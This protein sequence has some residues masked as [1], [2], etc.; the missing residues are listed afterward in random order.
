MRVSHRV[1]RRGTLSYTAKA[2]VVRAL[3][4]CIA[5]LGVNGAVASGAS[6]LTAPVGRGYER[7]SPLDKNG[8]DV[9]PVSAD[10]AAGVLSS[11]DGETIVWPAFGSF[12]GS[13]SALV[14]AQYLSRRAIGEWTTR[15]ISPP[16]V[17]EPLLA[18]T[19]VLAVSD[20]HSRAVVQSNAELV[21][22]APPSNLFGVPP[23]YV[24]DLATGTYELVS[25]RRFDGS[26][27]YNAN[28][29]GASADARHIL[30]E[31]DAEL[32]Q[33][34]IGVAGTRLYTWSNGVLSLSSMLPGNPGA[35]S[36]GSA[37]T[38][39]LSADELIDNAV[40][41]DGSQV[42][43]TAPAVGDESRRLYV[44]AD[45]TTM[46]V[47]EEEN[48]TQVIP[49]GPADFRGATR[50]G[51]KIFFTSRQQLVAAD[52]N[53]PGTDDGEDLYAYSPSEAPDTDANLTLLSKN[54]FPGAESE[55]IGFLGA[56][57]DGSR[58]YF[59]ANGELVDGAQ[60]NGPKL[61]MY[62]G[63]TDQVKLV[64]GLAGG[65]DSLMWG[66][67]DS[68]RNLSAVSG[69]GSALLFVT[70]AS[71]TGYNNVSSRCDG[72]ICPQVFYYDASTST[73]TGP[74]VKC[75]SCPATEGEALG[76][77]RLYASSIYPQAGLERVKDR[78]NLSSNGC[79]AFFES[80]E[81][82]APTDSNGKRDVYMWEA[83]TPYLMSTGQSDR[84][85]LFADASASGNDVFF[86]TTERLVGWDSDDLYDLYDARVGGG[87]PEPAV[88]PEPCKEDACQGLPTPRAVLP[89][90]ATTTL[91][92]AGNRRPPAREPVRGRVS[93]RPMTAAQR[94]RLSSGRSIR[95]HVRVVVGKATRL[96]V[97]ARTRVGRRTLTVD[98]WSSSVRG[99]GSVSVPLRMS[100]Q[101][102]DALKARGRLVLRLEVTASGVGAPAKTAV[103]LTRP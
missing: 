67:Q 44:R 29:V 24:H 96:V 86:T 65:D 80:P 7:V 49:P 19:A 95:I 66:N 58:V 54:A 101:T 43:F 42:V 93:I 10:F 22:D 69:D 71:L 81:S 84:E 98:R 60:A 13:P 100:V 61:Y 31:A 27:P 94:M 51:S 73:S 41:S 76:P 103:I 17:G 85:S 63:T 32:T 26:A 90:S 34:S 56:S 53:D 64:A 5:V 8:Q 28:F 12:A 39:E 6:A 15:G 77:A 36:E 75:V 23:L 2:H 11:A 16:V 37:G 87:L 68:A 25:P 55:V 102:R 9:L 47:A 92:G 74:D 38:A 57:D 59:A 91:R 21:P 97:V 99:R 52:T 33:D 30:F 45:G 82:L 48:A 50:N 3:V 46:S 62:D 1:T 70:A 72:G 14:P 79:R 35:P 40:S 4:A 20:D 78:R 88:V 83:G 18:T 89:G